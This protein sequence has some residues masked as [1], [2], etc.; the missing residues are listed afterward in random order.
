VR[1]PVRERT[2]SKHL[3]FQVEVIDQIVIDPPI[4]PVLVTD[5]VTGAFGY[6]GIYRARIVNQP[7]AAECVRNHISRTKFTVFAPT[8]T[9][10]C[11]RRY[12]QGSVMKTI[13]ARFS[14]LTGRANPAL[15]LAM[16]FALFSAGSALAALATPEQRRACTPDVYRLCAGEIPNVQ[17]ITS[18]LRRHKASL[19]E[20]C[21]VVFPQ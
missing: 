4:E 13:F 2:I 3:C 11:R 7:A 9:A 19:S 14:A 10:P 16:L 1:S 12:H 18:C 6:R 5:L 17:A 21:R 20:A 15:A 8:R